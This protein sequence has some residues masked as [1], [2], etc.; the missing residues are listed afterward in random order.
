[1]VLKLDA[2]NFEPLISRPI[3]ESGPLAEQQFFF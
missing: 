3:E 2:K 1:M